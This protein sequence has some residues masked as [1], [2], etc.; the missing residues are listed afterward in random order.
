M[1]NIFGKFLTN[2]NVTIKK[3]GIRFECP[4]KK[5]KVKVHTKS[6]HAPKY[7]LVYTLLVL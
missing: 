1:Y 2:F 4:Q 7:R 6:K 3:V 5:L